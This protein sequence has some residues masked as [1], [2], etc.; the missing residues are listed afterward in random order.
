MMTT[1]GFP[2]LPHTKPAV[3]GARP[4][5]KPVSAPEPV[6]RIMHA[7][8]PQDHVKPPPRIVSAPS[9]SFGQTLQRPDLVAPPAPPPPPRTLPAF[10]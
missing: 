2:R 6:E 7:C 4:P 5:E 8:R 1:K 3:A 10:M 9:T